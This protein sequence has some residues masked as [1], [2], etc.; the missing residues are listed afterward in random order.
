MWSIDV[1]QFMN[2]IWF[3]FD[4]MRFV[5]HNIYCCKL[6]RKPSTFYFY[7]YFD[8][9]FKNEVSF[10]LTKLVVTQ[11]HKNG[12]FFIQYFTSLDLVWKYYVIVIVSIS[13]YDV[14]DSIACDCLHVY[15]VRV[16]VCVLCLF[17]NLWKAIK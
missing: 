7:Y 17:T 2:L 8:M 12:R 15:C 11:S 16:C 4:I 1:N 13:S 3:Q 9:N 5:G 14:V 10:Y 6:I